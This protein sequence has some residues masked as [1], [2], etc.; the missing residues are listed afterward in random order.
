M[1]EE[2]EVLRSTDLIKGNEGKY[3]FFTFLCGHEGC[4]ENA[5]YYEY[6]MSR[7]EKHTADLDPST[8]PGNQ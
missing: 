3:G 5:E 4:T 2:W 8:W 6:G 7:C 1:S